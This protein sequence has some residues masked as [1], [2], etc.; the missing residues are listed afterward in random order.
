MRALLVLLTIVAVGLAGV[1]FFFG[2]VVP[3][4]EV[5]VRKIAFGPG[6]GLTKKPLYPG[7]HWTMPGYST[8]YTV[9]QGIRILDFDRDTKNNP[10]SHGALDVPTVD[11]TTVDIDASVLYRFY[12]ERAST[13]GL[14][15]G[16]AAD[17]ITQLGV[18][19]QQWDTSLSQMAENQL[20]RALSGLA[21][22]EFY[23]PEAR[24][25]RVKLAQEELQKQ[26]AP[27]GVAIEGV[28]LRRYT[29]REEIDQAIFKKNLQELEMAFNKVS[30]EF[31]EAQRD[32][33]RVEADGDVA[34]K[35]LEKQ[36]I[37][38]AERIRSEGD[39]YRR[40]K[41]AQGDLLVAQARAEVDRLRNEVLSKVGSDVYVALQLAQM[42]SSLKGGVIA[43]I[44]PYNLDAWT[45]KLMGSEN[46]R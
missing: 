36:G 17:L 43:D 44:D 16:G 24:E 5:G 39:L 35:N 29:Y 2:T 40:E 31:A 3:V 20:K 30:G 13:N 4:G 27:F 1:A 23:N 25:S 41:V 7:F 33:N 15:H 42:L 11:G 28:L 38:E 10:A 8:I 45:K 14:E 26:V 37:G 19:P 12:P 6:Q 32:V 21:T 34:I 46:G 9:P 22:A 18:T